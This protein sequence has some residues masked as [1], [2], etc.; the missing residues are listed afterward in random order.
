MVNV[1]LQTTFEGHWINT[2]SKVRK[3]QEQYD[4]PIVM[5]HD[6]GSRNEHGYPNTMMAYRTGGTP[7][8]IVV[9][10]N[11]RVVFNGFHINADKAIEYIKGQLTAL[12]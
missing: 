1:G 5:G 10:P 8:H 12:S 4:L 11:G 6:P 9:A 2:G 3:I 7:W